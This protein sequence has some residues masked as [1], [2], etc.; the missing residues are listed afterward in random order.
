[1]SFKS[2]L[3]TWLD[4]YLNRLPYGYVTGTVVGSDGAVLAG[5][6]VEFVGTPIKV[7]TNETGQFFTW[8]P[9]G[10]YTAL[11]K[12]P[13]YKTTEVSFTVSVNETTNLGT[14]I[15]KRLPRV[16]ILYDYAGS[17]KAFLETMDIYA[18][19]YTS[20]SALTN[21]VLAGLYDAV[22]WAGYY[23]APF[24]SCSEFMTFLNATHQV[25]V[26]VV[27]M[28][29]WGWYGY[30]IKVLYSCLQDPP[31]IGYSWGY[32]YV[33]VK[34]T[35]KH[36]IL[37]G[38]EVGDL[39]MIIAY[40]SA[41]FSWFSGFSGTS[42]ADTLV[43]GTTWGNSIAWKVFPDGV[44][45]ALLSSFAPTPWNP[46]TYFTPD[47]WNIIYNAVKWVMTKPLTV[48]LENPY[49]HV[50]DEALLHISG[51]PAN[52]TLLVYL[53]GKLIGEVMSN[54]TGYAELTFT[55]PL[56][57]GGE[58][59]IEVYSED[60]MYYGYTSL[61]VLAKTVVTP[62]ETTA[63]GLVKV[64]VTG[65][66]PY[67][68]VMIYLDGNW[69]SNYRAN[70][71]G[72]FEIKLNIPFVVTGDHELIIIDLEKS[73]VLSSTTLT[74]TSRLDEISGVITE[75][76]GDV[77]YIKTKVGEIQISLNDLMNALISVNA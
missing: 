32:G 73:E 46:P 21:D 66:L 50:G 40:T 12:M 7:Y 47:A 1:K 59:L 37:K 35:G 58:H 2:Y 34:V 42:I 27:W 70:A 5:A 33:Y 14:I 31:S 77:V 44:K 17:I 56:I 69:L 20:L 53:D 68:A 65:L 19:D 36:P 49:L 74:I 41:D 23:G 6:L 4:A 67:Q 25:G 48:V 13:G 64:N 39:V 8:L 57:P 51:A 62:T 55:V 22:V 54:G 76:S 61:Y 52:T 29:S 15:L 18:V 45:W 26:G 10:R 24:P 3:Y 72:T 11:I 16:A 75:I 60:E 43:G 63:P 28:D 30:G 71:L 9:E 38:Y